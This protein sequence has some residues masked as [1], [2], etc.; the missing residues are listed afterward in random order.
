MIIQNIDLV[1]ETENFYIYAFK[2]LS[3]IYFWNFFSLSKTNNTS[4]FFI[5]VKCEFKETIPPDWTVSLLHGIY[6]S[7]HNLSLN[8]KVGDILHSKDFERI[9]NIH[10]YIIDENINFNLKNEYNINIDFYHLT[11][12]TYNEFEY[13][14]K[15]SSSSLLRQL[16]EN[17]NYY[18]TDIYR[19]DY[20]LKKASIT[21]SDNIYI[22]DLEIMKKSN[23]KYELTIGLQDISLIKEILTA[24]IKKEKSVSIHTDDTTV[25]ISKGEICTIEEL[26]KGKLNI[27]LPISSLNYLQNSLAEKVQKVTLP[28]SDIVSLNIRKSYLRN[29]MG[30]II[31][32]VG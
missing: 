23:G 30:E 15:N 20:P 11:G 32:V 1:R 5:S 25:I 17:K 27:K 21:Y 9:K 13:A 6:T 14:R 3:D 4:E 2:S 8:L 22:E 19:V 24:Q 12:I 16:K 18:L 29:N 10:S 28:G 7:T 26:P 31:G